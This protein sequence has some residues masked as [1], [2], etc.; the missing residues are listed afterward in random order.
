MR[1]YNSVFVATKTLAFY[2]NAKRPAGFAGNVYL[3]GA[4]PTELAKHPIVDEAFSTRPKLTDKS[5]GRYLRGSF[6]PAWAKHN[7][8]S[9]VTTELKVWPRQQRLRG[10]GS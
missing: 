2:K 6:N 10:N 7:Q 9:R 5:D 4:T 3:Q 8:T 1:F